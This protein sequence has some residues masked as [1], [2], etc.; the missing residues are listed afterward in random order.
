MKTKTAVAVALCIASTSYALQITDLGS[1]GEEGSGARAISE[2]GIVVGEVWTCNAHRAFV[3][4]TL[5]GM[6]GIDSQL[7]EPAGVNNSGMIIG[8]SGSRRDLPMRSIT[9]GKLPVTSSQTEMAKA[10]RTDLSSTATADLLI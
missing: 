6:R 9:Q 2:S 10:I 8:T 5:N 3:Y 7:M 4:D 1:M